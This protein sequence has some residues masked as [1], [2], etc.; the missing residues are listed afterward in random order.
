M[1]AIV[2]FMLI[3]ALALLIDLA[4]AALICYAAAGLF[5]VILPLWPVFA[6]ILILGVLIRWIRGS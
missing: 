4:F 3:L 2:V 6:A 1:E 5:G